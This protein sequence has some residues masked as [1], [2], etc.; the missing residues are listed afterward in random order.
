MGYN[1]NKLY[2]ILGF[3]SRDILDFNFPEKGLGLVIPPHFVYDLSRKRFL[4]LYS[5]NW[6]NSIV[7][8]PLL[9]EI[10]GN[11]CFKII[12]WPGCDV[13]KFGINLIFL[14][15]SFCYMTKKSRQKFKYLENRQSFWAQIKNIFIIFKGLS[16]A[17]KFYQTWECA[18][19]PWLLKSGL[20]PYCWKPF[21]FWEAL[22]SCQT[23]T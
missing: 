19:N 1:K 10:L 13:T 5:S 20:M 18:F 6:P 9:L 12:C 15:K 17:K 2:K 11:M 23:V 3:W 8:L 7:W 21:K 14:I 16:I 22:V 4:M